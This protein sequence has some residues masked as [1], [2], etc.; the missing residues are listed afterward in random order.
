M[1][2]NRCVHVAVVYLTF[3]G[4]L[5]YKMLLIVTCAMHQEINKSR[6][7]QSLCMRISVSESHAYLSHMVQFRAV[8]PNLSRLA[9]PCRRE[10]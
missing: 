4:D 9:A 1:D 6:H 7:Q 2:G 8:V 3:I 10:L 5:R